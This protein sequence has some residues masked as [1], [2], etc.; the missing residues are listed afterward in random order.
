MKLTV[1]HRIVTRFDPPR[2]R[3]L[4]S[5]RVYPTDCASQKVL[6][7]EITVADACAGAVFTDGVGDQTVTFSLPGEVSEVV[8]EI[9]GEVQTFDTLGVLRDAR[10]KV[11]PV[12]YLTNT[13]LTRPDAA[14]TAMAAEAVAGLDEAK[15]LDRAHHLAKAVTA[16]MTRER[17]PGKEPLTGAEALDAGKGGP[18]DYA[19]LLIAACHSLSIPARF[20]YGYFMRSSADF[21]LEVEAEAQV[22]ATV[23]SHWP[24]HSW[25]EIWVE[26]MGWVGFDPLEECCPD[27]AYIRLCSGRD[28]LDAMPVRAVALGMGGEAHAVALDVAGSE[29]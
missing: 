18:A 10:E 9:K 22:G 11:S 14:I 5:M 16:A 25:A 19:H 24:A 27:E 8:T 6:N 26:G 2:R 4:Q 28:A 21:E 7:W 13:R 20:V 3:L 15:G 12:A 23:S 29:Q 17:D 1:S